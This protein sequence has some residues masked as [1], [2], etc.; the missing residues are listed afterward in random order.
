MR[1]L[2]EA[3][4]SCDRERLADQQLFTDSRRRELFSLVKDFPAVWNDPATPHRERKRM[5]GLLVED[6]TLAKDAEIH[7]HVRFRGGAPPPR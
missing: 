2:A 7:V 3:E 5:L 4:D 1:A 6:V